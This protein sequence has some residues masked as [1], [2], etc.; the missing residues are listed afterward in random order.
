MSFQ[1]KNMENKPELKNFKF[2][3]T[4]YETLQV[5]QN[6]NLLF[7]SEPGKK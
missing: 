6:V 7:G 3:N 1:A 4:F 2:I 5:K